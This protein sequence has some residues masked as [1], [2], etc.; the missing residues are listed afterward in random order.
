MMLPNIGM[1]ETF[2]SFPMSFYGEA[3]LDNN[4]LLAG[5]KIQAYSNNILVG[6]VVMQEDGIYGYSNPT[7]SKLV[8]G[9]Y[10]GEE[11]VFKYVLPNTSEVLTSGIP[12]VYQY[13]FETG[14]AVKF[15]IHFMDQI[16]APYCGDGTCN[17]D[18]TCSS[19]SSDCGSCPSSGG[20]GGSYS[21]P[22]SQT[23]NNAPLQISSSQKGTLTQSLNNENKV[24][25]EVPKGSVKFSVTFTAAQG[26]LTSDNVPKNKIGA[27]LFNGPVFNI[28]A[29]DAS[30]NAVR[31]FFEDLTITLTIPDLPDD[32]SI[33]ELYYFDDENNEWIIITGIVFGDDTITFK[34]NHLTQFA[35]FEIRTADIAGETKQKSE[36][37]VTVL[38]V[39]SDY[40]AIQLQQ[41]L[42]DANDVWTGDVNLVIANAGAKRDLAKEADGA[43]KYT[44]PLTKGISGLTAENKNAITNFIVYGTNSTQILGAGERAGVVNSYKSAFGK[45]PATQ[46]EWEDVIKIANGRWPSETNPTAEEKAKIEFRKVYKKDP[47]MNNPNDNAAVTVIAYGLRPSDR[48]LDSEKAGIKTFKHIYG[49]NPISAIDWDIVRAIAYS[50]AT[51]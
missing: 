17:G 25:L 30:N 37:E 8:I 15:D 4:N 10:G 31:E 42:T 39:E 51:R 6:E 38:G 18:E 20:G 5:T 2:P 29:V 7:K 33:L 22:T 9:E 36:E 47:D 46:S 27:F 40:R 3:K 28:E 26:S 14:K 16:S 48:N 1:A 12:V 19:C 41:I 21:P 43:N 35:V 24:K 34:V 49:Y 45:L 11:L 32:I 50:G 13:D 23:A 44:Q